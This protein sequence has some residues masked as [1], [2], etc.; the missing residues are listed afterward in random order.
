MLA[1][2]T[3]YDITVFLHLI[4]VI[5]AFGPLLVMGRLY[6]TDPTGAAKL[7]TRFSLP[8]LILV[9]VL[10]MGAVGTSGEGPDRLGKIEMTDTWI[11]LSLLI[12]VVLVALAI[13]VIMPAIKT[14]SNAGRSR[15][16]GAMGASHLLLV[17]VVALMVF[18]PG[19]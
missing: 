2:S 9:W 3:G 4:A 7:Y 12:W 17:V 16:M 14:A 6:A 18:K 10:G 15:L 5:S 1:A 11:V 8:S 19:S 13:G